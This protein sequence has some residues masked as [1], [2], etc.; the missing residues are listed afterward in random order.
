MCAPRSTISRCELVSA[1]VQTVHRAR[2]QYT[3]TGDPVRIVISLDERKKRD[4]LKF[5][6]FFA[7]CENEPP[8]VRVAKCYARFFLFFF[9]SFLSFFDYAAENNRISRMY[10][11]VM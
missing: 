8:Y 1:P 3:N 6:F 10:I 4:P 2:E 7:A 9:F 11:K 5:T